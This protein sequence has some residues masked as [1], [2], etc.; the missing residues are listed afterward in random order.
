MCLQWCLV[1]YCQLT[2]QRSAR[3]G[4]GG[5][6]TQSRLRAR[7]GPGGESWRE[8]MW[9][10]GSE[11]RLASSCTVSSSSRLPVWHQSN[12]LLRWIM[13]LACCPLQHRTCQFSQNQVILGYHGQTSI[14]SLYTVLIPPLF[15]YTNMSCM[16][17]FPFLSSKL[18]CV[19]KINK[20]YLFILG[21]PGG[22]GG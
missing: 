19:L 16:F 21:P 5:R 22:Q 6:K 14:Q 11:L 4:N 15:S 10:K 17:M 12:Q 20:Y 3:Y 1:W 18:L 13:F 9:N 8:A 7:T 2:G